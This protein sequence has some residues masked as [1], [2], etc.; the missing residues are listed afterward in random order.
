MTVRE[1]WACFPSRGSVLFRADPETIGPLVSI[2][3][4][5]SPGWPS[6]QREPSLRA[7]SHYVPNLLVR[8]SQAY[9]KTVGSVGEAPVDT[10]FSDRLFFLLFGS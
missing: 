8:R 10:R 2:Q 6:A 4:S 1:T 5:L 9:S 7:G 3:F